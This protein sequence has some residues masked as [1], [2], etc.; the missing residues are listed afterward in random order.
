VLLPRTIKQ[1]EKALTGIDRLATATEWERAAIVWAF[2]YEGVNRHSSSAR[3]SV[4]YTIRGFADLKFSGLK[5]QDTIRGYRT[6]WQQAIDAGQAVD[7]QPGDEVRL[8]KLEWPK[9]LAG[10]WADQKAATIKNGMLD[11][12]A[13]RAALEDPKVR[14]VVAHEVVRHPATRDT[15]VTESFAK[16][17]D[18]ADLANPNRIINGPPKLTE[19]APARTAG[20][21]LLYTLDKMLNMLIDPCRR[22]QTSGEVVPDTIRDQ[23]M[24]RVTAYRTAMDTMETMVMGDTTV[25]DDDLA[26][27][28]K[29]E[30]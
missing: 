30:S 1:A 20:Q 3:H 22:Y 29:G 28:L 15:I 21:E 11:H 14:E 23:I 12:K 27:F 10:K 8:P 9:N 6:A 18:D 26:A 4:R 2:T 19:P 17:R 7:V 25:S 5:T 13:V 16:R 24:V